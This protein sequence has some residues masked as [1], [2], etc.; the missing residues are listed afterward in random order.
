[1]GKIHRFYRRGRHP[2]GF[3]G[4]RALIAMN[5]KKHEALPEWVFG[6]LPLEDGLRILDIGCG[7]G[8]N[9]RRL[10]ERCPKGHVTG[11]DISKLAVE[12]T[13]DENYPAVKDGLCLV[14][15]GN[16]VQMP[17]AKDIFDIAFAFETIYYWSTI[18]G[19]FA[20]AYRVLKPGGT[21]V[22]ANEL[23]GLGPDDEILARRV[24]AMRIYTPDE[25]EMSL[26]EAGFTDITIDRDEKCHFLYATAKKS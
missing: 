1:M 23:D 17:L 9:I 3:W 4:R 22:I 20:E 13:T 16:A 2:R 11:L 8:G 18:D 15:G 6:Q 19:G 26:R 14:V 5:G 24:G 21:L 7:G 12:M 25:I 10:L